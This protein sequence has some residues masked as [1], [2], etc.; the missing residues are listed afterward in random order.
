MKKTNVMHYCATLGPI[1]YLPAPGTVATL[2]TC[3]ALFFMPYTLNNGYMFVVALLY[4]SALSFINYSL[5][6]FHEKDP[7]QIVIDEVIGCLVTFY[8]IP[9][10]WVSLLIGFVLF[11]FFDITKCGPVGWAEKI[12]GPTGILLDDVFAGILSN[13]LLYL[14]FALWLC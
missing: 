2:L 13:I 11:R 12:K 10:S 14:L 5:K 3:I 7:S 1:G 6:N 4:F 9:I 8:A